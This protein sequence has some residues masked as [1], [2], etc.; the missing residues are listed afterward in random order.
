MRELVAI[1]SASLLLALASGCPREGVLEWRAAEVARIDEFAPIGP[2]QVGCVPYSESMFGRFGLPLEEA[3]RVK[4]DETDCILGFPS[5]FVRIEASHRPYDQ[6]H[7]SVGFDDESCCGY[8]PLTPAQLA[9]G[10]GG[11]IGSD[12]LGPNI[13]VMVAGNDE[14]VEDR[15]LVFDSCDEG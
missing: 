15:P 6:L 11:G 7:F 4:L 10:G 13:F 3:G 12:A 14:C 8:V 5:L 2:V 9:A 1:T